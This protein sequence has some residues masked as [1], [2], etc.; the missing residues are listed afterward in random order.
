MNAM[1]E[2]H[3]QIT[4]ETDRLTLRP[5]RKSDAGLIGLYASDIRVAGPLRDIPHPL[6][7]GAAEA[8]IEMAGSAKRV[9]DVWAIDGTKIDLPEV[10][11]LISLERMDRDQSELGYWL[12]PAFW[13]IGFG[14]EAVA[15][16]LATNPQ[17]AKRVFAQVMQD[18]PRS[19]KLLMGQGF[20]Y[21]GDAESFSVARDSV[22][23]TWTYSRAM[24]A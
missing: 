22:V 6:P 2:L 11:G 3:P 24:G 8:F 9:E 13:G 12:S 19:A 10:M 14:S 18:N 20:D 17:A 5:L 15:A 4:L 16:I 21:L 1:T 23:Q 7:P